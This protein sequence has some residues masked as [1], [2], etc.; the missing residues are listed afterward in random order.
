MKLLIA[1]PALNEAEAIDDIIKRSLAAREVIIRDSPVDEVD[2]TIVSDGSTDE[3]VERASRY[4]PE[5]NLVVFPQNRGY[6]AA[7]KEAW[8]GSDA[9]LL[10]FL[11]ADGTCDPDFF[12]V[13]C[14]RL[15]AEG[16][17]VAVGCR[18][19]PESRMPRTRRIGNTIFAAMLTYMSAK[20]VRDVASGM[21]V[22]RRSSL[23]RML[24][25]PDG[26]H[27][28]PAMSARVL[29]GGDLRLVEINMP[30][31]ERTGRSKLSV[32]RDGM[33]FFRI[34]G[35]TAFLYR[36]GRILWSVA[37]LATLGSAAMIASPLAHYVRHRSLADWMI[38]RCSAAALLIILFWSAGYLST[39]VTDVAMFHRESAGLQGRCRDLVGRRAFTLL[40]T[41]L[42]IGSIALGWT[43]FR[44][45]LSTGH[46]DTHWSRVL[47][48]LTLVTLA[49]V[50]FV[51]KI[52]D[53]ALS[54]VQQKVRSLEYIETTPHPA[55]AFA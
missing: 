29:L 37:A 17:D 35:E 1:V 33:R 14:S 24:P 16:A 49:L 40:P 5:I 27:F 13:L 39:R 54:L 19:N 20:G 4:T 7:I 32:I 21:R 28:T 53:A 36:P 48:I 52:L 55:D 11:D 50:L 47:A 42:L 9:D 44:E 3:T 2:I 8:E 12:A 25:L 31:Q 46:V 41:A 15:V 6:G 30:Y 22:V 51:L 23:L 10:G 26:L 18:M 38:Y 45:Y 43:G 34:I